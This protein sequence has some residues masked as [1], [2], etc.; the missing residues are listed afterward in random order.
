[1]T[2]PFSDTDMVYNYNTHRYTLTDE[3]V[4]RELNM[5]LALTLNTRGVIDKGSAVNSFLSQI[6]RD[7]YA[8]IY[9]TNVN[10]DL[11]EYIAAKHPSARRILRDA[12]LEQVLYVQINGDLT[13]VSGIDLRKGT[14]IDRGYLARASIAPVAEDILSRRLDANTPALAFRGCGYGNAFTQLNL[15]AYESEGY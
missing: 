10:N 1:M 13:K 2:Y 6:S 3:C 7:I 14:H 5:D 8:Y 11:Q 9:S 15:P 12:M 4:K